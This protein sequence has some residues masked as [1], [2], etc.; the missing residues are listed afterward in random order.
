MISIT[1]QKLFHYL[2]EI[3]NSLRYYI[4]VQNSHHK[5]GKFKETCDLQKSTSQVFSVG[6]MARTFPAKES[7]KYNPK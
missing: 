2:T 1:V 3:P 7:I 4:Y 6:A 5:S